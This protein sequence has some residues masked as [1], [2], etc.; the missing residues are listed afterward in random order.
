MKRIHQPKFHKNFQLFNSFGACD[1][2][3]YEQTGGKNNQR[4]PSSSLL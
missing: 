3:I 1:W 2:F 4:F